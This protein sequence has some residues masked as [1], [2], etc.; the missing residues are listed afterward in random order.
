RTAPAVP[1]RVGEAL[2]NCRERRR[3][4]PLLEAGTPRAS[5]QPDGRLAAL[6][7]FGLTGLAPTRGGATVGV[8]TGTPFTPLPFVPELALPPLPAAA[9]GRPLL[10][11]LTAVVVA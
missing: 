1:I 7:F 9:T 6:P 8:T 2:P 3:G 10:D 4:V 5:H 11:P